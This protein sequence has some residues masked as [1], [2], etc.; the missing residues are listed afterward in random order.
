MNKKKV[1]ILVMLVLALITSSVMSLAV[2]SQKARI[3]SL[4]LE[5]KMMYR[6]PVVRDAIMS[7]G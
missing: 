4:Q 1:A 6:D 2:V 7:G 3:D 5:I